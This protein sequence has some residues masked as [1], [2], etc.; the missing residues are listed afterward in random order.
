MN[1]RYVI[2][3]EEWDNNSGDWIEINP[4]ISFDTREEAEAYALSVEDNDTIANIFDSI[5]CRYVVF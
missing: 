3:L 2:E 4:E 5:D 1:K